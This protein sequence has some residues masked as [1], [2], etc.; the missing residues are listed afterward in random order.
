VSKIQSPFLDSLYDVSRFVGLLFIFLIIIFLF[1]YKVE[2][3]V[4]GYDL[5]I[6]SQFNEDAYWGIEHTDGFEIWSAAKKPDGDLNIY[7]IFP[8]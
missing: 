3:D 1:M 4:K 2:F 5:I 8:R 6:R 7:R